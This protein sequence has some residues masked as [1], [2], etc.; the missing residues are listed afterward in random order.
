[1]HS[2]QTGIKNAASKAE[3]LPKELPTLLTLVAYPSLPMAK[4]NFNGDVVEPQ[5]NWREPTPSCVAFRSAVIGDPLGKVCRVMGRHVRHLRPTSLPLCPVCRTTPI[6]TEPQSPRQPDWWI[7]LDSGLIRLYVISEVHCRRCVS[8]R[9]E[10]EMRFEERDDRVHDALQVYMA[11]RRRAPRR[12]IV[13]M[14]AMNVTRAWAAATGGE[15]V[16]ADV[17]VR[18]YYD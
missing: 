14:A 1:M 13:S 8:R 12:D 17:L 15:L 6:M 5:R 7:T 4:R 11:L 18:R 16:A 2:R 9:I 3:S 10:N